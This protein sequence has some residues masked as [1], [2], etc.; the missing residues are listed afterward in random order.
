VWKSHDERWPGVKR[1][2]DRGRNK[3]RAEEGLTAPR[4]LAWVG[5][6]CCHCV[7]GFL[8]VPSEGGKPGAEDPRDLKPSC[9][10]SSAASAADHGNRARLASRCDSR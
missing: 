10:N 5:L 8:L 4:L 6:V 2:L 9:F 3:Q 7:L 1:S